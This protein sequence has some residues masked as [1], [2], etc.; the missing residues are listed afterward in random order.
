MDNDKCD[1]VVVLN[2]E[3]RSVTVLRNLRCEK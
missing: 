3:G 2:Q 1:D